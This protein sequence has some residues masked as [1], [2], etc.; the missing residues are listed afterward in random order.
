MEKFLSTI[1][2]AATNPLAYGAYIAT[3]LAWF[4][5]GL[6]VQRH[7]ILL[8]RLAQIPEK[9][10]L[11]AIELEM[12]VVRVKGGITA[13]QWLR[14]RIH[15]YYIIGICVLCFTILIIASLA[16]YKYAGSTSGAIGLVP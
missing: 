3:V 2:V 12:G 4:L 9:D 7:K 11:T 5:L 15:T 8:D 1:Q 13:E 16:I 10:R 14:S 6:R